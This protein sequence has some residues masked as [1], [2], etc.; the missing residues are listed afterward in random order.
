[1]GAVPVHVPL[2]QVRA[3]P[4]FGVP[5]IFGATVFAGGVLIVVA[6]LVAIVEPSSLPAV[7][8]HLSCLPTSAA[9]TTYIAL[10]APA[11]AT[12]FRSHWYEYSIGAVPAQVPLLQ[13]RL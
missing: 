2:V 6:A 11:I 10:A 7:T 9:L 13:V 5:V 12:L 8:R 1:M 3:L 4:T